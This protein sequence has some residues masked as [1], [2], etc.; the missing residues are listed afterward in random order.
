LRKYGRPVGTHYGG[1]RKQLTCKGIARTLHLEASADRLLR[2]LKARAAPGN[3]LVFPAPNDREWSLAE[4][5]RLFAVA[6]ALAEL[7]AMSRR[8]IRLARAGMG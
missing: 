8:S 5:H 3:V 7:P 6:C 4:V 1:G 2:W